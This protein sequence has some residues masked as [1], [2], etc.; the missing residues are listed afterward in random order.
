MK[1]LHASAVVSGTTLSL[2]RALSGAYVKPD[3][4]EI[5][6]TPLS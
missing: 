5:E 4:D 1:S 3:Q 2:H 6:R